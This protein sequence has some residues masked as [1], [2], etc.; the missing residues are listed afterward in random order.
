[1]STLAGEA[2][3]FIFTQEAAADLSSNQFCF[4][5]KT[6]VAQRVDVSTLHSD[7]VVGVLQNKPNRVGSAATIVVDGITRIVASAAIT[8]GDKL[9][10]TTGG[11]AV[12]TT[13]SG[14][15]YYG[16][17]LDTVSTAGN[18]VTM[19]LSHGKIS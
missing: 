15:E 11:Q 10:P 14:D 19:L 7:P 13:T 3:D 1:V 18:I 2:P 5:K 16:I 6:T 8:A 4:L 12:A 17:A 9:K